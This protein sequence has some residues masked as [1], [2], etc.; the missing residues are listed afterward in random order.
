MLELE[1][2]RDESLAFDLAPGP[3]A[4]I[5]AWDEVTRDGKLARVLWSALR[6]RTD[7]QQ[8]VRFFLGSSREWSLP[9]SRAALPTA[10]LVKT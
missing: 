8:S 6:K 3:K 2:G 4:V 10:P 9:Q 7:P 5:V 1:Q